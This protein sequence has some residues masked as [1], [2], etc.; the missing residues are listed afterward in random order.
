MREGAVIIAGAFKEFVE[1]GHGALATVVNDEVTGDGKEPSVKTGFT[2]VLAA[3]DENAH[4]DLLKEVFG[5]GTVVGEV[6]EIAEEPMLKARNQLVE[7][8][9]I[10]ALE[11]G[12]NGQILLALKLLSGLC[13]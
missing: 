11:P 8:L 1:A 5:E 12:G 3:A 2:V 10:L 13:G 9:G 4:P 6:E 7:E